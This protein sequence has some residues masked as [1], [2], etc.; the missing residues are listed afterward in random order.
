[1][2]PTAGVQSLEHKWVYATLTVFDG[3]R[4]LKPRQ[5]S[6]DWIRFSEPPRL[7]ADVI[8]IVL[9]NGDAEQRHIATVLPHDQQATK[10]PIRLHVEGHPPR[11]V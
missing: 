11:A 9:V 2:Q 10:I 1:M 7:V 6:T 8:E 3:Q 4:K 5:V